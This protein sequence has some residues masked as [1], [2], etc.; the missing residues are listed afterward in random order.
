[1]IGIREKLGGRNQNILGFDAL[2]K[3]AVFLPLVRKDGELQVLFQERAHHLKRQPGE[4]CFPGGRIEK[5]DRSAEEAAMRETCEELGL[6]RADLSCYG[7]LDFIIEPHRVIYPFAG[8]I[9]H[10]ER[11]A[12]NREEVARLHYAPLERLLAAAPEEHVVDV[13]VRPK[14]DFPFD[15]LTNERGPMWKRWEYSIFFYRFGTFTVWG[16]TA[17]I[18]HHFLELVRERKSET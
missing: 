10:P 14:E 13:L 15:V 4:I 11:I 18:L 1:M 9:V 12:M 16:L 3:Y 2:R 7:P 8:E 6:S 5:S 17:R